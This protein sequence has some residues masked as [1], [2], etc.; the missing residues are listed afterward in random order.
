MRFVSTRAAVAVLSLAALAG[1]DGDGGT[2][3]QTLTPTDVGGVYQICS[4]TFT[5]EGGSPPPVDV[6]GRTME[7]NPVDPPVIRVGRQDPSF[8]LEYTRK[9]DVIK[10]RVEGSYTLSS[11]G[12]ALGVGESSTAAGLLL[13]PRLQ[14]RYGRSPQTLRV[15]M[16]PYAVARSAYERV[17][18]QQYPN[19]RDQIVGTLDGV[20]ST[21]GC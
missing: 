12:I 17:A 4:L 7:L 18:G 15:D 1:C 21:A 6:R 14:L 20:F 9:G 13:P 5:P 3:S 11:A 8:Q 16:I 19:A 10:P 2:G